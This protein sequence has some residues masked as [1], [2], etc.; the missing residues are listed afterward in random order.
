MALALPYEEKI[1]LI[2]FLK[3]FV[4]E[5]KNYYKIAL[6]NEVMEISKGLI[7][8]NLESYKELVG[9]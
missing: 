8:Q 3:K 1:E 4:D 6:D 7:N 9:F 2:N 5:N